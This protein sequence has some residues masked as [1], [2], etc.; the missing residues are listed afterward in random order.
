MEKADFILYSTAVFDAVRDHPFPG[1]VVIQGN[2]ILFVGDRQSAEVYAGPE[3]KRKDFG[4]QLIMPGFF[5]GHGH[6]QTAAVREFGDCIKHLEECRSEQETVDGVVRYLK[7]NPDCK[8]VHGRCFF[9]TSWGPGAPEPTR[10]SLDAAVPE[11]PVYLLSSSGHSAWLNSAAMK[12]CDLEGI[13]RQHPEWPDEY[14]RRDENGQLT[15]F[16]CE[17][18][19]YTVR[20]MVEVYEHE[21]IARW[22]EQFMHLLNEHGITSFTECNALPPRTQIDMIEPL[23]RLENRDALTIRYH[24]W[25]GSNILGKNEDRSAQAGLV[26]LQYL[27]TYFHTDKIRVAGAKFMLDGVPDTCTGA[28]LQPYVGRPSTRGDLLSDPTAFREAVICANDMGFSVKVHCLG[29]RSTRVTIDAF[30]ESWK[31]HGA[32]RNA[33]EHMNI[34][35]D[36]DIPRMAKCGIIASVQPAHLTDWL[37]GCGEEIYGP[38]LNKKESRYRDLIDAGVK[39]SIGTDTPVVRI[40]PI[41]T[42]YAA[43]TRRGFED[44]VLKCSNPE[45]AMTMAEVL[46][47]YTI[48]AA[49]ASGFENKVGTLE[50]GKLADIA[51]I[52]QNLFAIDLEKIKQCRNV[53][54][55]FDGKIV[56]EA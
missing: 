31:K 11:I 29:D 33:V 56:Y 27:D 37:N 32:M 4:D 7:E 55:I 51:V 46:K 42:I 21:D 15:G 9:L 19:S 6:Y 49:Y 35:S 8:R 52:S 12:E 22:D 38:E 26:D 28:M 3:T 40:D 13:I 20:Y 50:A 53:C 25:C 54:T 45:Q 34:I 18:L 16:L 24:Q 41:R 23:K 44:G 47:G 1:A 2:K 17:N 14:A 48:G 5:D 10:A 36:E 39:I 43:V 30:E